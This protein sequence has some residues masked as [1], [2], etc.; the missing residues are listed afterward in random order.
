MI[1]KTIATSGGDYTT[2]AS[3]EAAIGDTDHET[4]TCTSAAILQST[5]LTLNAAN[6]GTWVYLLTANDTVKVSEPTA[7]DVVTKA[8]ITNSVT[9]SGTGW[10]VEKLA[11]PLGAFLT[12]QIAI[13]ASAT[14]RRCG[15]SNDINE[16]NYDCIINTGTTTV[17]DNCFVISIPAGVC[18][19]NNSGTT[20]TYHCSILTVS[21]AYAGYYAG[22]GT[23]NTYACIAQG[24]GL[25][26]KN[27]GATLGGDYN[28]SQD[29]SAVGTNKWTSQSSVYE[30]SSASQNYLWLS[31]YSIVSEEYADDDSYATAP[32]NYTNMIQKTT[33]TAGTTNC[34]VGSARRANAAASEDPGDFGT[35]EVWT[36]RSYT[37]AIAP[38]SPGTTPTVA[39][40]AEYALTTAGTTSSVP[41]TSTVGNLVIIF[42]A[43]GTT[44]SATPESGWTDLSVSGTSNP[45][46]YYKVLDGSEGSTFDATHSSSKS[47]AL[48]Y[49]ISGCK[50]IPRISVVA[51]NTEG[52]AAN[53]IPVMS[54]NLA[55]ASAS[56]GDYAVADYTGTVTDL[57][58]D[59]VGTTRTGTIDVGVWQTPAVAGNTGNFLAFM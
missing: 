59:I 40:T 49:N 20:S 22:G 42:L 34:L 17:I 57:T 36:A 4:G 51:S 9:I 3:W 2:V 44:V 38:S 32:T 58:T 5:A 52:N 35:A 21:G 53:L 56:Q 29:T 18:I 37:V 24:S 54:G 8:R 45:K 6:T 16:D 7:Y 11:F 12:T 47:C 15:F 31:T 23:H 25:N 28:V 43:T 50:G 39:A 10:V 33:G 30:Y 1:S 27:D 55:L 19:G 13:T 26:W 14:V 46:V 48:S 41:F